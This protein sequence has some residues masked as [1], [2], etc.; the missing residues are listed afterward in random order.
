M[1][2]QYRKHDHL[3][4]EGDDNGDVIRSCRLEGGV[5]RG[6]NGG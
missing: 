3:G 2:S 4:Q 1:R 6:Q 5:S